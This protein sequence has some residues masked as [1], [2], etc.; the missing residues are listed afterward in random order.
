MTLDLVERWLDT[1]KLAIAK[2]PLPKDGLN[3]LL[4]CLVISDIGCARGVVDAR[5]KVGNI[6][7]VTGQVTGHGHRDCHDPHLVAEVPGAG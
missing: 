4:N 7:A 2:S 1:H 3:T 5:A 6:I